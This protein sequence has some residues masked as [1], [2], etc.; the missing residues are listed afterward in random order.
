MVAAA[1]NSLEQLFCQAELAAMLSSPAETA[2]LRQLLTVTQEAQC[3]GM[4]CLY[5]QG[6]EL[7]MQ[8]GGALDPF[9]LL[10]FLRARQGSVEV[11]RNLERTHSAIEQC[12]FCGV[13]RKQRRCTS[14]CGVGG[15]RTT[16][17][18]C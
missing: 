5:V 13:C 7:D 17:V 10:R 1:H 9:L 16:L 8:G 6:A 14:I 15:N 18:N 2:A 3:A 12:A 11:H 4:H